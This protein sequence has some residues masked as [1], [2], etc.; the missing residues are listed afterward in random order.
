MLEEYLEFIS[1][2][3]I[4][5]TAIA[6]VLGAI[7]TD[8][9]RRIKDDII[10]PLSKFDFETLFK[11]FDIRE[12]IGLGIHFFMQTYL[13]Y[14]LSKTIKNMDFKIQIPPTIR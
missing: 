7:V 2:K 13:L 8:I 12:Y 10:L 14:L 6:L 3:N 9:V 5:P 1:N 4:L 11:R